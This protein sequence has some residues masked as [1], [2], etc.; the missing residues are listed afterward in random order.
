MIY[1]WVLAGIFVASAWLEVVVRTRVFRRWRR[2]LLT[3]AGTLP[4]LLLWDWYAI[5]AGHWH[6]HDLTGVMLGVVPLEELLF[7]VVVPIAGIL[8]LEAVRAVR[9]WPTGDELR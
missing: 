3:L 6:F 7:F 4:P 9:G 1:L 8:S 5:R 2:L